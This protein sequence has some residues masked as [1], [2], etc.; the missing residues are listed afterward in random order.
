[1]NSFW[2]HW[3]PPPVQ[4]AVANAA[5]A[6]ERFIGG[7]DGFVRALLAFVAVDYVT[8][9]MMAL[10]GRRWSGDAGFRGLCRKVLIFALVGVGNISD[11]LLNG[12][13][14]LIRTAVIFFFV[15]SEGV[16]ILENAARMGLPIPAK[17]KNVLK[18]LHSPE[19]KEEE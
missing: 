7:W 4:A 16:S 18:Q 17:L 9:L 11:Q 14:H 6:L 15:S 3:I 5:A 19:A 2:N 8:G 1:M 13:G 12:E 10:A